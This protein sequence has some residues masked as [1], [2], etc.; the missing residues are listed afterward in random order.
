MFSVSYETVKSITKVENDLYRNKNWKPKRK[1]KKKKNENAKMIFFLKN[2]DHWQN[3]VTPLYGDESAKCLTDRKMIWIISDIYK[4][5]W[6]RCDM[7]YFLFPFPKI[8]ETVE[9]FGVDGKFENSNLA[10]ESSKLEGNLGTVHNT[11][12][13]C[14]IQCIF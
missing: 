3:N 5:W 9:M 4:Y 14:C 1:L 8:I 11:I 6:R 7:R 12:I 10:Y 2:N 13:F